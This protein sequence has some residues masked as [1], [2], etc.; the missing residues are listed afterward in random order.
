MNLHRKRSR[1]T[2]SRLFTPILAMTLSCA[3]GASNP[4][5]GAH[6]DAP[7]A[8]KNDAPDAGTNDDAPS[9]G[10][11]DQS[12]C[13]PPTPCASGAF[14]NPDQVCKA[15]HDA[16]GP[17][18]CA[19]GGCPC[20]TTC[21]GTCVD[22]ETDAKNC[23]S[24]HHA[25][26]MTVET[27][28]AGACVCGF[29]DCTGDCV[30]TM[31]SDSANCGGCGV[32]CPYECT[33]GSCGPATLS[34]PDIGDIGSIVVDSTNF[35]WIGLTSVGN[36]EVDYC[37]LAGCLGGVYQTLASSPMEAF[38]SISLG[39]LAVSTSAAYF[40]DDQGNVLTC[41]LPPPLGTGCSTTPTTFTTRGDSFH[42]FVAADAAQVYWSNMNDATVLDCPVGSSCPSPSLVED[43]SS[44]STQ[45]Q[46]AAVSGGRL[47]WGGASETLGGGFTIY[48]T[49]VGGGTVS[50]LC[51]AADSNGIVQL[52]VAGG[53]VYFTDGEA[54]VFSCPTTASGASASVFVSDSGGP[55]GLASDG[56]D[57]YWTDH[58]Y[59]ALSGSIMSC[60]LGATCATSGSIV[61]SDADNAPAAIAVTATHIYWAG[62]TATGS[63][64][65]YFHK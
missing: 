38:D 44:A 21:D 25:C 58:T 20:A 30:D 5:T 59:L 26:K 37:P 4:M 7:D 6:S 22:L 19:D 54:T 56:T 61:L 65:Q 55:F 31:G 34:L 24:C 49:P 15:Q 32:A 40:A 57:L 51:N 60:A 8:A 63:V 36:T 50:T 9:C 28:E 16:G 46:G 48:S 45:L 43:L 39:T 17:E 35:Y 18:A 41:G 29:T 64:V 23:G 11:V 27:C 33:S 42:T 47:Y 13:A 3:S 14:C 12:C 1:V 2:P 52:I 10:A 53:F 62:T